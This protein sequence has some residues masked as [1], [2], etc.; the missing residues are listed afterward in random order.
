METFLS[1]YEIGKIQGRYL[2][3][4]LPSL[5]FVD[6]QFELCLCSHLLFLYSDQL[7]LDF[8]LVSINRLLQVASEVRIF[9]LL[10]LNCERSPYVEVVVQELLNQGFHIQMQNVGYEF[11]KGGNQML[12]L[13]R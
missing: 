2:H 12:K 4:S 1:D 8:H 11:Q 13:R 7:S 10:K 9:P 6:Q 3:Q 5:E